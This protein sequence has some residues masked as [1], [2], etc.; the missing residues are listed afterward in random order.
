VRLYS[1]PQLLHRTIVAISRICAFGEPVQVGSFAAIKS[2]PLTGLGAQ[3][4]SNGKL[5]APCGMHIRWWQRRGCEPV[6]KEKCQRSPATS[7]YWS[8]VDL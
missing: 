3:H 7:A 1:A 2:D 4:R 6:Q 8:K 5:L